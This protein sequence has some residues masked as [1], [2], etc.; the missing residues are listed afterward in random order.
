[1]IQQIEIYLFSKSLGRQFL[2]QSRGDGQ[3]H[4]LILVNRGGSEGFWIIGWCRG[5]R[6]DAFGDSKEQRSARLDASGGVEIHGSGPSLPILAGGAA[7]LG[8]EPL[9]EA[10]VAGSGGWG[11][12]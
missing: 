6:K 1:M 8:T 2:C 10:E 3:G 11:M 7:V 9:V 4:S 12:A 5:R